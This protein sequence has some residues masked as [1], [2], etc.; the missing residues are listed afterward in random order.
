MEL[1]RA[2]LIRANP[3]C[4]LYESV[5]VDAESKLG[6][7]NV[8]FKGVSLLGS[9]LGDHSYLQVGATA[10]SC[11]IGKYC[12]IAMNTYIGL[13]QHVVS[14]VSSH[15]VFYLENTPLVRK[16]CK[17]DL[18]ALDQR[19]TIGHDVWIGHAA[20]VMAGVKIGT[21]AVV[22]A[23]AVV[24]CDVPDYAIVGGVPARVIRYRFDESLRDR[25]LASRWWEMPE[26]WLEANVEL[27][28]N[29]VELLVAIEH[30][31][32]IL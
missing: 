19:T 3:D 25:L 28:A 23:G 29:P 12:S 16:F 9:S 8:L 22:G 27:F 13:P 1:R 17:S 15:P 5:V 2:A 10:L 14:Q 30:T 20:L 26:S 18:V 24:T 32:K 31:K 21:G 7:F 6:R 4:R 11:D